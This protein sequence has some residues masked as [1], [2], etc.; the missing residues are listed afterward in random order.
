MGWRIVEV[1][2][3]ETI[4]LYL[5]NLMIRRT[6]G[7]ILINISDIDTLIL[8]N[9][10]TNVSI[11]LLNALARGNVNVIVMDGMHEPNSYLVPVNG[12]HNSLKILEK[13]I[14][15]TNHYKAKLWKSIIQNKLHNQKQVLSNYCKKSLTNYFDGLIT[16]VK[17]FDVTN[18][19]G[20]A[21]KV[22]WNNIFNM[23]FNRDQKAEQ[24]PIINGMLNYGY[25]VLRSLVI[26]SIVKK[27]L[28]PRI[29]LFH[30]SFSNFFALASDLMEPL[31]PLIDK[32]VY[33]YRNAPLFT[34][35]IKDELIGVL[36]QKVMFND[37][38]HQINNAID[39]SIDNIISGRG[40]VWLKLCA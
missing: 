8:K 21:A 10:R 19:E 4:R 22:Y 15:W 39:Q 34:Y 24:H 17:A 32:I 26:R 33:K 25:A 12:N 9:T 13:Q 3:D 7:K 18:R 27:G 40:W 31:R 5:N 2:T 36:E 1:E 6:M 28:D 29:S 16:K 23:S 11:R 35:E 30:K 37:Q 38:K 20:H 14:E